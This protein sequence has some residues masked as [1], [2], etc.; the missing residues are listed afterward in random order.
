M[1]ISFFGRL[2]DMLGA[3]SLTLESAMDSGTA[4]KAHLGK[5]YPEISEILAHQG[6]R[7]V[8]NDELVDWATALSASDDIAI[9]PVV[10]GG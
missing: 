5:A 2:A 9:I 4:L 1:H 7:L 8:I 10:S 6:T 3:R